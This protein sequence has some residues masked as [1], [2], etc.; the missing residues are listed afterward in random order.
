ML[1]KKEVANTSHTAASQ[2]KLKGLFSNS[3]KHCL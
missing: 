1:K 2:D 3:F